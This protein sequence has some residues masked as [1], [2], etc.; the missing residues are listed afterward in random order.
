MHRVFTWLQKVLL[1]YYVY[2]LFSFLEMTELQVLNVQSCRLIGKAPE[3][4]YA[5][6]RCMLGLRLLPLR[7]DG[8]RRANGSHPSLAWKESWR[9]WNWNT[10]ICPKLMYQCRYCQR[11][12]ESVVGC[13]K[14]RVGQL[15]SMSLKLR[16]KLSSKL[17]RLEFQLRTL[18]STVAS[19]GKKSWSHSFNS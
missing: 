15:W 19:T 12:V 4:A 10:L 2:W 6:N 7:G 17:S 8:K 13:S 11:K 18:R 3:W 14:V 16:L 1:C 5:K 9:L